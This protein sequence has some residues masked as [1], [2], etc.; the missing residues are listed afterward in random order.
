M[1][2]THIVKTTD[3]IAFEG[4]GDVGR[5]LVS[6]AD[7]GGTYSLMTWRVAPGVPLDDATR[8]GAHLHRECE[9]TFLVQNGTLEFLRGDTVTTLSTGDFVRVPAGTRHGYANISD[10]PVNLLVSFVP[11]G[12]EELFLKYRTDG[13]RPPPEPGFVADATD[14]FASEF[15]E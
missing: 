8:F 11:A 14:H 1:T 13:D 4:E 6:G 7:T 10:A 3:G 5:I 9:E 12:L 2:C 15:E